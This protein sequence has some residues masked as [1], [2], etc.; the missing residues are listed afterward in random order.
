MGSV[1]AGKYYLFQMEA[2]LND[3]SNCTFILSEYLASSKQYF[4]SR[5]ILSFNALSDYYGYSFEL[6]L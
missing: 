4:G 3:Q 5:P 2:V 6:L 1:H